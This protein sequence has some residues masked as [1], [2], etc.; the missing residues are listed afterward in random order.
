M[1]HKS[2]IARLAALLLVVS[3]LLTSCAASAPA[4]PLV[5]EKVVTQVVEKTVVQTQVVE[6]AVEK[7]VVVTATPAPAP[8]AAAKPKGKLLIWVQKANQDVFEKTVLNDFKAEYPDIQLEF[9]NYTPS[10]VAD[11]VAVAIQGGSGAPDL[12]VTES[13]SIGKLVALGGL[14]DITEQLKPW[15]DQLNK[16]MLNQAMKDG[17]YYCATWD[18]GPVVFFYRRDV[19]KAAGLSD[20]PDDVS[21][22]VATWDNMLD[23][24]KTIKDKTGLKCFDQNKANNTGDLYKNMLWQQGL[25]FYDK[26]NKITIDAPENVATL[27]KLGEF[28]KADVVSDELEWTDNWYADL[29]APIDSKNPKPVA[30]VVIAAWMGNFLKTWIAGDRAGQWGVAE[31]PA[32]K[33]GGMRSANQG[34][35]CFFIP[36]QSTNK[37]AAWAFIQFMILRPQN[38]L[39]LFA[40]SD[41]FPA[42]QSIYSDALFSE[43]DSYFGG[44]VTRQVFAKAAAAIPEA[45]I[46]GPYG[47]TMG[48]AVNTAVQK[49]A[50][51][52]AT[53]AQALK[54]AADSVRVE[55]GL[56]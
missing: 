28:W 11:K 6:K 22:Q 12:G 20:N 38:D 36:E 42:L 17:K 56:K 48:T 45:N 23:T 26:D 40:Y 2:P 21:K 13:A 9:V 32:Y 52:N 51:G 19:F 35:S 15:I 3:I 55:T 16:P 54:E 24:C 39:K 50:T 5:V 25:G 53:A 41:Y 29:K 1:L 33:P 10:D 43:P 27:E 18:I 44:Q 47:R 8:S 7:N 30:G 46:Y 14:T 31:M 4:A 49:Y 37:D 34:G